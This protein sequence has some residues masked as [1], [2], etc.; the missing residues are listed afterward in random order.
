MN[1]RYS[2]CIISSDPKEYEII[3]EINSE[4]FESHIYTKGIEI[5]EALSTNRSDGIVIDT[6]ILD[7]D[8]QVLIKKYR[9]HA[10]ENALPIMVAS[11]QKSSYI[12]HQAYE[13]GVEEFHQKPLSAKIFRLKCQRVMKRVEEKSSFSSMLN[14]LNHEIENIQNNLIKT[15]NLI[16]LVKG[17]ESLEHMI[18]IK[19]ISI[20]LGQKLSTHPLYE[21]II[22]KKYL[23]YL[24]E[25]APMHDIGYLLLPEGI[26]KRLHKERLSDLELNE[27]KCH[28]ELGKEIIKNISEKVEDNLFLDIAKEVTLFHHE[29]WDGSGYPRGIKGDA[30]PISAQIVHIAELYDVLTN[31]EYIC[32]IEVE[33]RELVYSHLSALEVLKSLSGN[34]FSPVLVDFF[35]EIAP[36]VEKIAKEYPTKDV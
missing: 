27:I 21:K 18:R 31:K 6:D 4:I 15:M 32:D 9:E 22:T 23:K 34:I 33:K 17:P 30:I 36:V 29:A 13:L 5:L 2:L 16:A 20:A 35:M 7:I 28:A 3:R 12:E 25:L 10:K 11:S 14:L 26:V 19:N 24:Y 8:W 1:K